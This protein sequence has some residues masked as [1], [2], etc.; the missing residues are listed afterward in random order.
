MPPSR[1]IDVFVASVVASGSARSQIDGDARQ[2]VGDRAALVGE[3]VDD[4]DRGALGGKAPGDRRSDATGTAGDDDPR[5]DETL[6]G[7]GRVGT[8]FDHGGRN[9]TSPVRTP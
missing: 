6:A 8:R 7:R 2:L 5:A 1:S 9:L 3:P 4:G